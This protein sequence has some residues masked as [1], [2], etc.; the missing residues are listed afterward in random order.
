MNF[1]RNDSTY[2]NHSTEYCSTDLSSCKKI[3]RKIKY[4]IRL[5]IEWCLKFYILFDI[6]SLWEFRKS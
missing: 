4:V 3:T 6:G 1:G 2:N 5:L